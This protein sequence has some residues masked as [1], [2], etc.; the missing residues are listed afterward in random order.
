[1]RGLHVKER[2]F[3]ESAKHI[4]ICNNSF[5]NHKSHHLSALLNHV[6]FVFFLS[7]SVLGET[8]RLSVSEVS[9][10]VETFIWVS[11]SIESAIFISSNSMIEF[12]RCWRGLMSCFWFLQSEFRQYRSSHIYILDWPIFNKTSWIEKPSGMHNFLPPWRKRSS[13]FKN[14][15]YLE[16]RRQ[17][18]SHGRVR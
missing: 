13:W 16:R 18:A 1:M 10:L 7:S 15:R 4:N 2:S 6:F 14:L 11:K 17:M 5:S 8:T 3:A 12:I 9:L